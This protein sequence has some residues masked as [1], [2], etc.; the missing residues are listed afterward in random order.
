MAD[1]VRDVLM[2]L[3][4]DAEVGR[5]GRS[6]VFSIRCFALRYKDNNSIVTSKGI[7]L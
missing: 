2:R 4:P 6:F 1:V 5:T 7:C 3:V